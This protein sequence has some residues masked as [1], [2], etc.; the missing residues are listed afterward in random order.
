MAAQEELGT[1]TKQ[2]II[3]TVL[4]EIARRKAR[5]AEFAFWRRGGSLDVRDPQVMGQAWR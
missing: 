3:N 1:H 4:R 2:E 5:R